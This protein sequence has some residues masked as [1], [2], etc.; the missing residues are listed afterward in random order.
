MAEAYKL[1]EAI[2]LLPLWL[3]FHKRPEPVCYLNG[4]RYERITKP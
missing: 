1:I 2:V 3:M 4:T